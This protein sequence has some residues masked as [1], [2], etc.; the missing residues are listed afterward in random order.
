MISV[1]PCGCGE[2]HL[3]EGFIGYR[4][5]FVHPDGRILVD[6]PVWPTAEMARESASER[7]N[8]DKI[9]GIVHD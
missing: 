1:L 8:V 6:G 9:E 2:N 3:T 5:A 7:W 4:A